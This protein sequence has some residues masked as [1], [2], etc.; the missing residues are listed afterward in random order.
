MTNT[1]KLRRFVKLPRDGS[2][3]TQERVLERN[4]QVGAGR[5]EIEKFL[6][7]FRTKIR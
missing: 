1:E 5:R 2:K 3:G 4:K 6:A 7:Q